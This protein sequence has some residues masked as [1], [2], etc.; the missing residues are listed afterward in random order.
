MAKKKEPPKEQLSVSVAEALSTYMDNLN[1]QKCNCLYQVT[2]NV[3]E[4]QL[5]DFCLRQA[6]GN[7][8]AAAQM[9]GISRTTLTR[10]MA[11]H[12]L[13]AK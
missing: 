5:F 11:A 13:R 6:N 12:K 3:V 4:R 1:G 9:L 8:S 10:K 7:V 2:I